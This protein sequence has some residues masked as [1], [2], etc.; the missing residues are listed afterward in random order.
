MRRSLLFGPLLVAVVLVSAASGSAGPVML[1]RWS[2]GLD[3][4]GQDAE[5][6]AWCKG[7]G[8]HSEIHVLRLETRAERR[9]FGSC[10]AA[11]RI[12]VAYPSIAWKSWEGAGAFNTQM[13]LNR[14]VGGQ[15]WKV[16]ESTPGA[17]YGNAVGEPVSDGAAL[18]YS[19]LRIVGNEIDCQV[20]EAPCYWRI[21]GGHVYR[22][23]RGRGVAIPAIPPRSRRRRVQW[24]DRDR[25]PVEPEVRTRR[26][27]ERNERSHERDRDGARL[28]R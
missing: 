6:V 21:G 20:G 12:A 9:V 16:A 27:G 28:S 5:S 22:I 25:Q 15:V 17:W 7:A 26:L 14:L 11:N 23:V 24:S 10:N 4:V 2:G 1:A 3:G 13:V 8:Y 19:V 18:F